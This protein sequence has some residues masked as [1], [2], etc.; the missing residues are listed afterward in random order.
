MELQ[1]ELSIKDTSIKDTSVKDPSASGTSVRGKAS[2]VIAPLNYND[3]GTLGYRR[4]A[5]EIEKELLEGLKN[6]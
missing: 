1:R 5:K 3:K 6:G 2:R 4:S